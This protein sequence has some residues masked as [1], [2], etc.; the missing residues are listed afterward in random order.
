[1]KETNCLFSLVFPVLA[2]Y[3]IV[4]QLL[5]LLLQLQVNFWVEATWKLTAQKFGNPK[6]GLMLNCCVRQWCVSAI[7]TRT[8]PD[9]IRQKDLASHGHG[10]CNFARN[11]LVRQLILVYPWWIEESVVLFEPYL[12]S[13]AKSS[14]AQTSFDIRSAMSEFV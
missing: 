1:M 7:S 6:R 2:D 14:L 10:S 4:F 9:S 5:Q 8:T 11:S 13:E 3:V 12:F